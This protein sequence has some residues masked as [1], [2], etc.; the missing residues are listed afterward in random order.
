MHAALVPNPASIVRFISSAKKKLT[1][2]WKSFHLAIPEWHY[3]IQ[4]GK[5][6]MKTKPPCQIYTQEI[7]RAKHCDGCR[8][9]DSG[10]RRAT[11]APSPLLLPQGD[12]MF[13][14]TLKLV[15]AGRESCSWHLSEKHK[16]VRFNE[17]TLNAKVHLH[18]YLCVIYTNINSHS[19]RCCP[20][21]I[22]CII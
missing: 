9:A 15:S 5:G 17:P 19:P 4:F 21:V 3:L 8:A 10:S 14:V 18:F 20:T 7:E 13:L 1:A 16:S 11:P 6:K 22:S 12:V 2:P